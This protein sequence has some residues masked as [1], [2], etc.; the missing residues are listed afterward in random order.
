MVL[1]LA[2]LV[3]LLDSTSVLRKFIVGHPLGISFSNGS[4]KYSDHHLQKMPFSQVS[5]CSEYRTVQGENNLK[6]KPTHYITIYSINHS[7]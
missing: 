3:I 5:W 1:T 7:L 4:I 2:K 6:E